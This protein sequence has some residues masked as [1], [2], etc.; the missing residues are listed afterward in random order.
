M[1][2]HSMY[3]KQIIKKKTDYCRGKVKVI[4]EKL[5]KS[6][7]TNIFRAFRAFI[8]DSHLYRYRIVNKLS[9]KDL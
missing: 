8:A 5:Y 4:P 9:F 6:I 2:I 3:K 1:R 7:Y